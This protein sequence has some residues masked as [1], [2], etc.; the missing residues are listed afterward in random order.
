MMGVWGEAKSSIFR[1][2]EMGEEM[3]SRKRIAVEVVDVGVCAR[4]CS[5]VGRLV[6]TGSNTCLSEKV[7][8][9]SLINALMS[10]ELPQ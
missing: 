2:G 9:P 6:S 8:F 10:C 5:I 7:K 3:G 1:S 4:D